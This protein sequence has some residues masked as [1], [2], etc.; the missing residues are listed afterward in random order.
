MSERQWGTVR[1]DYSESGEAWRYFP[2]DHARS[3][4]YRWGEDGIAGYS[5]HRQRVC[6]SVAL[7]NERDP[8]LKERLFGLANEEGNHGE[9]VKEQYFYLDATPTHSYLKM[10]YKYPQAEYP[11]ARLVEEQR[12]R[13]RDQP[14]FE[15]IDTG[16]FDD[17]R[18]FDVFV[19]YGKVDP[20]DT[21]IRIRVENRGPEAA[22][23]RL[24]PQIFFR[25]SWSWQRDTPKPSLWRAGSRIELSHHELKSF[26][27]HFQGEPE[28]LF[29]EN[30]TNFQR[31]FGMPGP[32]PYPKDAFHDYIVHGNKSVVCPE[33]RGTKAALHFPLRVEAGGH[34]EVWL[35]LSP[36]VKAEPFRDFEQHF[37]ERIAEADAFYAELQAGIENPDA[38]LV[39]RQALAGMIWSKQT[40]FYDVRQWLAG[41]ELQPPPPAA[42]KHGRNADWDH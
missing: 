33:Q 41:D 27:L 31:V 21:L 30:E 4:A 39:Q 40:Y 37:A 17:G 42:R 14:E 3:R 1:E 7:W 25:N 2:H 24:L 11:Y 34:A 36:E 32:C 6:F 19:E 15:L 20:N 18:Y 16:V 8:I 22:N 35:R 9:D 10:L 12:R 13:G 38:R 5:D 29:C 26:H 28:L 23:L